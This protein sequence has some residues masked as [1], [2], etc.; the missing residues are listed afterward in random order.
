MKWQVKLVLDS[1]KA[2]LPYQG[3]L[4]RFK[5]RFVPYSVE[6]NKDAW[7]LE[8]G[9][10][11]I[12]WLREASFRFSGASVLEIG[13]GWQPII[14][15]LYYLVGCHKIYLTDTQV[16]LDR[17][18]VVNALQT[19]RRFADNI[20]ARLNI[21]KASILSRLAE[22]N[23]RDVAT[24]LE[25]FN[26]SYLAPC[27][28]TRLSLPDASLDLIFSRA[29]LEHI[30]KVVIAGIFTEC[31]RILT[32]HGAMLHVIDNS[33][34]WEHIDKSISSVNFL[35]F[36]DWQFR[37]LCLNSLNYHNRLR[38]SDYVTLLRTAGF[39]IL[40]E[41]G[42]IDDTSLELLKTMR[43][44]TRFHGRHHE[45]LATIHSWFLARKYRNP[46]FVNNC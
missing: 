9:L 35:K 46:L 7:T 33:D 28:T 8:Q 42:K 27:D 40:R 21:S 6:P 4:R 25:C 3:T 38:H 31:A 34:H 20:S 29:V 18:L 1:A 14:P 22:P 2:V 45:D 13:T 26:M 24:L 15:L 39:E 37:L 44:S 23:V 12:E 30:P 43:V 17:R 19:A 16:L 36:S 5:R 41:S 32:A 11:Q 10:Q